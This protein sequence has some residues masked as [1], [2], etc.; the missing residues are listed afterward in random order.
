MGKEAQITHKGGVSGI[1]W[2]LCIP[3]QAKRE[4]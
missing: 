1:L 4:P 2:L 3:C